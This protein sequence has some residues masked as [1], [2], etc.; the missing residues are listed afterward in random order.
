M[1]LDRWLVDWALRNGKERTARSIAAEKKLEVWDVVI[2][3]ILHFCRY[4]AHSILIRTSSI[5]TYS[6]T[7]VELRMLSHARVVLK[8]WLG[9]MKTRLPCE[10]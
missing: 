7:S 2:L 9:V 5:S 10:K 3:F 6:M 1:R 4:S 8:R